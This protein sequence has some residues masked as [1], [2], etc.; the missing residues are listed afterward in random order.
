MCV[1]VYIYGS[2]EEEKDVNRK[3]EKNKVRG[4]NDKTEGGGGGD[5]E[6]NIDCFE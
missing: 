3:K 1:G 2:V 4:V 6:S 5:E